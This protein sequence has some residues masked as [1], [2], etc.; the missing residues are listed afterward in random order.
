MTIFGIDIAAGGED[1]SVCA[2][3]HNW[4]VLPLIAWAKMEPMESVGKIITLKRHFKPDRMVVDA[5]GLGAG[6]YDRLREQ[7]TDIPILAFH[8]K[9]KCERADVSGELFFANWRSYAWWHMRDLLAPD[10]D[11]KVALPRDKDDALV[12]ELC[13]PKWKLTSSGKIQVEPKEEIR[14]RLD[15]STDHAD[16]VIMAFFDIETSEFEDSW[17]VYSG[18]DT[19][20]LVK[21][22]RGDVPQ[23]DPNEEAA[24]EK[25]LWG[26]GTPI[27]LMSMF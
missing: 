18:E 10:C 16:A 7:I 15:R 2:V 12:G 17:N 25:L 27:D 24:I 22:S 9:Y 26:K 21:E 14:K 5:D 23:R 6:V 11:V 19:D 20:K 4:S 3:R 1:K 13:A 8:G